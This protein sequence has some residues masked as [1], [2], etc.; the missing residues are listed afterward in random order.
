MEMGFISKVENI[1]SKDSNVKIGWEE[2]NQEIYLLWKNGNNEGRL[3]LEKVDEQKQ[4][5]R[6][7][8]WTSFLK[9][10]EERIRQTQH[11]TCC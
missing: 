10:I 7:L 3:L 5:S 2:S 4:G 1:L 8:Y 9:G 11:R 6:Q